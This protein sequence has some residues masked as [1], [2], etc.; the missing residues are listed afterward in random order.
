M[1]DNRRSA[2]RFPARNLIEVTDS[3]TGNV[4]GQ[5]G[6]LSRTGML[7]RCQSPLNDDAVYQVRFSLRD[8]P[9]AHAD[10]EVGIHTMWTGRAIGDGRQWSGAHIIS[11]SDRAAQALDVW[12]EHAAA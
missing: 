7:L 3:I 2:E 12:L 1:N 9:G 11:I 5:I 6:N 10:I 8:G 4:I